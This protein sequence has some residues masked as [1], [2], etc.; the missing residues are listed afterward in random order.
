MKKAVFF[1]VILTLFII[2][3]NLS[4]AALFRKKISIDHTK[5]FNGDKQKFPVLIVITDSALKS[6][7]QHGHVSLNNA[8]DIYFTKGDGTDRLPHEILSYDPITGKIK[9]C[10][11]VPF[12]SSTNDTELFMYYGGSS[13]SPPGNV[14][15]SSY[16]MILHLGNTVDPDRDIPESEILNISDQITVQAWVNSDKYQPEVMQPIVSKWSLLSTFN[17]FDA[18]DASK[19]DGLETRGYFG[20]V[21]DGRY[22]YLSPI[23]L[24]NDFAGAHGNILRYDTHQDFKNPESYDAYDASNTGGMYTKGYCGLAFD[25]RYVYFIPRHNGK[26]YH[27]RFL[28]YDT[29]MDFKDSASWD[30]Y[31]VGVDSSHQGAAFDGRYLYFPAAHHMEGDDLEGGTHTHDGRA[32]RFDTRSDFKDPASWRVFD[33]DTISDLE[34]VCFDGANYDG[35]YVYF[36]PIYTKI[37]VRYDTRGDFNNKDSWEAF[38]AGPLGMDVLVGMTF[39]G[40]Y[41]Y[42][43]HYYKNNVIR[44]DTHADFTDRRSWFNYQHG[45]VNGL[46]TDGFAGGFFDGKYVYYVPF[47]RALKEG[48]KRSKMHANYMRYNTLSRFDDPKSWEA[49]DAGKTSGMEIMGYNSGSFD[50]RYFYTIPFR[51]LKGGNGII[52]RYDTVGENGSF[53]LNFCN[54]GSNGGLSATVSGP[55]F[56][57]NTENG[58]LSI[59]GKGTLLPGWHHVAGVYDGKTI[60][61]FIDGMLEGEQTGSGAIQMNEVPVAIGRLYESS[62]RFK[63]IVDE[64]RISN[65]ARNDGWIKTEYQNFVNPDDFI[66][67]GAEE[68][69]K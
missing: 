27:S 54:N 48:D 56:I 65:V 47:E 24:T 14:W 37:V 21:F 20:A 34:S 19:T 35:R 28:R 23:R 44:Y 62:A 15:D 69:V 45:E 32:I 41:M 57:V 64:V 40:R 51:D 63:G 4:Y 53:I 50:G 7:D 55:S 6:T 58:P 16:S 36:T 13:K 11:T 29:H 25:G 61:L 2:S 39:D 10:V 38:D 17:S 59:L 26:E 68:N 43:V 67:V 42:P 22:I 52:L 46:G 3:T 31:D 12:V 9:A 5:V 30:A 8:G 60:K 49:F 18:Y 1:A 66:N 33:T